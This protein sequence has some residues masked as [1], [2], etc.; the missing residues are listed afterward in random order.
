[1]KAAQLLESPNRFLSTVQIGITLVG[2]LAGAFGGARIAVELAAYFQSF[3][4]TLLTQ[5]SV[6]LSFAV[7]VGIITFLS[8]VLGELVPKRIALS[9]PEGIASAVALPMDYLSRLGA[10]LIHLLGVSTDASLKLFGIKER[11]DDGISEDEV[12]Y[13]VEQGVKSGVFDPQEHHIVDSVFALGD[14]MVSG[15]M[16]SRSDV[17]WLDIDDTTENIEKQISQ[18][19]RSRFPVCKGRL[20]RVVG[21]VRAK[22]L[23]TGEIPKNLNEWREI[24]QKPHFVPENL[25]ALR[26]LTDFKQHGTHMAMVVDEYGSIVGL[27]TLHDVLEAIVGEL[28]AEDDVEKDA[29]AVQ[30]EDGSWLIDGMM[31]IEDFKE[32]F[33][34]R[35]FPDEE[36]IAYQT[37]SGFVMAQT[38]DIP[39]AGDRFTVEE[40]FFEVLAIEGRRVDKIIVRPQTIDSLELEDE[41]S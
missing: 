41:P 20:D 34:V 24:A 38:Q 35:Q 14:R 1:M 2:I 11:M 17:F 31:P 21:I 4:N 13:M 12:R 36:N 26:I 9:N 10:P 7:V 25:P 22:D 5:T 27:V 8:I 3:D 23:L 39:S 18:S 37:V 6:P 33:E 19:A 32:L 40:L 29:E 30:R 15:L 28:P 16:T